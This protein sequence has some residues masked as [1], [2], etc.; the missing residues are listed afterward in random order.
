MNLYGLI[1]FPLGHSF[2]ER[3]FA[4]KFRTEGLDDN[5]YRN[6]P[7]ENIEKLPDV[8]A[9]NTDL[10]G[11][12]VTI[13]Y[14]QQVMRYLSD[15]DDEAREIGAV[16]CVRITEHGLKGYNTDAYGFRRS[17]ERLLDGFVPER[18][19]ILGTGGAS[20]AVSYVL[21]KMGIEYR[22]VSRSAGRPNSIT[23]ENMTEDDVRSSALI[24]N[25]T[26][27]GTYPATEGFPPIKYEGIGSGHYLFDLV[28]NPAVTRFMAMGDERGA[29]TVNGY[30]MLVGQAE[31]S[32]EIWHND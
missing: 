2:S 28:Y 25:S 20:K 7:I 19:L 9:A 6:F 12:N 15:I 10:R 13:P 31:R 24:V 4:D 26:P 23:Y 29:R 8:L 14:K 21:G 3:F 17:L 16:N 30:E 11:F 18:A 27:L 22:F 1:G 32:W 5:E